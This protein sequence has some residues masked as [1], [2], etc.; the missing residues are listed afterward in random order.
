VTNLHPSPSAGAR[1]ALAVTAT[2]GMSVSYIDRQT[3]AAIAPAVKK[4]LDIDHTHYGWLLSAFSVAYLVGAPAAGIVV[5]RLGARRAFALAVVVWSMVAAAH[6]MITGFAMLFALRIL[7]G[8]AESPSFPSAAQAIRRALPGAQRPLAFG[9]LFTGS[10]IGA[11]VAGKLAVTLDAS[12]GWRN[13]FLGTALVGTIWLPAWLLAT[14]GFGLDRPAERPKEIVRQASWRETVMSPP[15]LRAIVAIV[16]S[17]P[18]LMFV[19]NWTSQYLV[20]AWH[21]KKED[22]GNH[23]VV[24]PLVFDVAAIA[25]GWIASRREDGRTNPR[26][27][28]DLFVV[29]A[30]LAACLALAPLAESPNTAIALFA[31]SAAGGGGIYVLVTADMLSRVPIDKTSS[32][33]GMTAAAQSLA[34]IVAAPL[35]GR[36]IDRTHG[37]TQVLIALGLFVLPTTLAFIAWPGMETRSHAHPPHDDPS[38]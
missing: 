27:H 3:L 11:V 2:L 29:A 34:H 16:G 31:L 12:F 9:L 6:W 21:F 15:V 22:V 14:R 8:A 36:S 30:L 33:G 10:S 1:W 19:L 23:L 18:A 32:A 25:F 26:T 4:A 35:M 17:A 13:A 38:R 7:L 24:A 5:D 28:V 37:Y 20:E